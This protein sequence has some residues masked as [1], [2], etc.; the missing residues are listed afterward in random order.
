MARSLGLSRAAVWKQ[1]Q[2]LRRKGYQISSSPRRGYLL[3]GQP[4][5][6]DAGRIKSG[7]ATRWLGRDLL[8]LDETSSTN[9]AAL[10]SIGQ[11]QS[12]SVILAETQREGRGR[13]SRPWASPPGGIWM[14]LVLKPDMSLS[15]VYR[16]NM[17][18]SVSLCRA[19]SRQ[20]GLEAGIKWPNDLLIREKKVCGI[21]MEMGAQVDRLDYVVVGVGLNANNDTSAFPGLWGSTSL[22]GQMGE[23]VDRCALIAAILNEME[24]ALDDMESQEL[25]QEWRSRS[26]TLGRQ[27]KISSSEGDI[28]GEVVD[29]DRDGALI[30]RQGQEK[31]RILAGDCI[32][33][34]PADL[35]AQ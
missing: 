9:R 22:V 23:K 32:H 20:L 33:L 1:I 16:I 8:I 29:L 35:Q 13:L 2:A 27:V 26:L 19:I 30:L 6:L 18:V 34:R 17:A 28:S 31:R 10:S 4:D 7:L 21:L 25:Y 24:N 12:G 11:K 3:T 5:L 14:S 15:R